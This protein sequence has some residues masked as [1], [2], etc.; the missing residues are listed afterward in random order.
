[1]NASE[2]SVSASHVQGAV[3]AT[4]RQKIQPRSRP[5]ELA[6]HQAHFVRNRLEA[7]KGSAVFP[8]P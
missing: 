5:G 1:M 3:P 7:L 6:A 8:I 2:V 4:I